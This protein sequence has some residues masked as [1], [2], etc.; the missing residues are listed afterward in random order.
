MS[1]NR[2]VPDQEIA[3]DLSVFGGDSSVVWWPFVASR[4][5]VA[6]GFLVPTAVMLAIF[7]FV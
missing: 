2:T 4:L 5:V 1:V 7:Q 3:Q 6:D